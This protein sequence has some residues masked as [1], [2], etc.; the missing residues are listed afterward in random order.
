MC[1]V[2]MGEQ[3]DATGRQDASEKGQLD[4]FPSVLT[5]D[6]KNKLSALE[7]ADFTE[8]NDK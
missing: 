6:E 4:R 3:T 8:I 2:F 1:S 5:K 7:K